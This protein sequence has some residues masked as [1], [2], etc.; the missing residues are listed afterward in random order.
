LRCSPRSCDCSAMRMRDEL[1]IFS[2]HNDHDGILNTSENLRFVDRIF[3]VDYILL[4]SVRFA[5]R[6]WIIYS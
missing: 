3:S 4:S 2:S 6:V 1:A 5:H